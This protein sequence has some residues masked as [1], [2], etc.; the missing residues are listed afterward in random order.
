MTDIEKMCGLIALERCLPLV[1]QTA[2]ELRADAQRVQASGIDEKA[3]WCWLND[4][5]SQA[6]TNQHTM[7]A[8]L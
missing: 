2:L 5:L 7:K 8:P 1:Q 3:V 4:L 6:I